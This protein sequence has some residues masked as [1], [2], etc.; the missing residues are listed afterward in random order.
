MSVSVIMPSYNRGSIIADALRSVLAGTFQDFEL[1]VVDD[2]SKDDTSQVVSGFR[3]SRLR[4]I[5][6]ETNRG[7]SSAYNTGIREARGEF[8]A[9]LDSDDLWKPEMFAK[10]LEFLERH[11]EADAVFTDLEKQ[12]S[13]RTFPSF[14]R[15]SPCMVRLLSAKQWPKEVSFTQREM[16]LCLLQEVPVKPS[17]LVVRKAA[18]CAIEPFNESWPSG[19]DWELLLRFSKRFRFGYID[20]PLAVLRVQSDATH[21]LYAVADKSNVLKMLR[22]EAAIAPDREVRH[23][24]L[25]GC[26]ETAR[27]LS[28]EYLK[29]G[30]RLNAAAA[31]VRGFF[32]TGSCGL[33]ARAAFALVRPDF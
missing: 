24:A 23:A 4:Y 12:D 3:D 6:H 5:R 19:S 26:W 2:G 1:I 8:V 16:Y 31:L 11:P 13:S 14:M 17:A 10:E 32:I 29:R 9:F 20:E 7:C 25:A 18:L 22:A 15:E 27:Q 33:L 28:W 30:K 21:R